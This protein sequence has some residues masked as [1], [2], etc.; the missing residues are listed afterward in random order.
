V[1]VDA[2]TELSADSIRGPLLARRARLRWDAIR[3]TH[4]LLAPENVVQLTRTA[5]ETLA[6]CDGVRTRAAV[7]AQLEA[8]YPSAPVSR[9]VNALLDRLVAR[10]FVTDPDAGAMEAVATESI[11]RTSREGEPPVALLAELTYRCPLRCGYCSNPIDFANYRDELDEAGW[12]RV[13]DDA[14]AMGVYHVHFS[15]GEPLLRSDLE[16]LVAH[17]RGAGLY[18]NLI[19]SAYGWSEARLDRLVEAGVDHIQVS[20][21][22]SEADSADRIAGTRVHREKI[23]AAR[24]IVARGIALSV[25]VVLH[26]GNLARVGELIALAESLGAVRIELANTQYH[27]WAL[28]NRDALIPSREALVEASIVADRERA[29]LRGR[30]DVIYVFPDYYT[31]VPKPC[32]DGWGRRF[33]TVVPDGTALPCPGAH[34]LPIAFESVKQRSLAWIWNESPGFAAYRGTAWMSEPCGSCERREVDFGG[35]RCQAFALTGDARATDPACA[36]APAHAIV[37][38]AR[39]AAMRV[40]REVLYRVGRAKPRT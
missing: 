8:K 10:G 6:L 40:P 31:D 18:T 13:I 38:S 23:A 37:A 2:M 5:A 11:A 36:K 4:V 34:A 21:Q 25:N 7:I 29:R 1:Q 16:S 33:V 27:G 35:C 15:G 39:E 9:D 14:A 3:K 28:S 12:K 32:M 20:F 19:T 22:D 26:R 17:A 24:A 30:M